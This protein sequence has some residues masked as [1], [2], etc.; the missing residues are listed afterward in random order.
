MIVQSLDAWAIDYH[1]PNDHGSTRTIVMVRLIDSDG[2]VGWGE[3]VTIFREAALA[4]VALVEGW[5]PFLVGAKALPA[6]LRHKIDE[7]TWWYGGG[8]IASFGRSA[9]DV[10]A[11]DLAA[12]ARGTTVVDLLGGAV[13]DRLPL[14]VTTHASMADLGAQADWLAEQLAER[15]ASGVKVGIGKRGDSDLGRDHDRDVD[16]MRR[17]R[18]AL[19]N[20]ARIMIDVAARVHWNVAEAVRRTRALEEYGLH[21]IEEPLGADNPAGY[22]TLKAKT[23]TLIAYGEREWNL[24]GI[25]RIVDSGSV[26]V[27]GIDAGRA[28]GITGFSSAARHIEAAGCEVNAHAFAGPV[29]F[30]AGLAG[31]LTSSAC[32][33]FE[34]APLPNELVTRLSPGLPTPVGHVHAL[35][36]PGLGVDIDAAAVI[37]MAAAS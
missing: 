24:R 4:T 27:I 19:P 32:N 37:A 11:W 7:H 29:S 20:G 13:Q 10:A 9:I 17:L 21:W 3:A 8:G 23:S 35:E 16:F 33:Q 26:D 1:E 30:A 28:E 25:A 31:S 15:A 2:V 36:G 34:V 14:V 5:S 6:V 12:R 22:S 18:G